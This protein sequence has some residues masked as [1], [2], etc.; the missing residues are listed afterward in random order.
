MALLPI[1]PRAVAALERTIAFLS[2]SAAL[3]L[4]I[5]VCALVPILAKADA[6]SIRTLSSRCFKLAASAETAG[7]HFFKAAIVKIH[8]L[9]FFNFLM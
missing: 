8:S 1:L 2:F 4:G 6:A 3:R 9:V 5:A 7:S